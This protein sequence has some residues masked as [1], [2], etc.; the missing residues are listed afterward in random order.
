M[1]VIVCRVECGHLDAV[2]A[3]GR[4]ERLH[5]SWMTK[6]NRTGASVSPCLT[7]TVEYDAEMTW[8]RVVAWTKIATCI[9]TPTA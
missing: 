4:L 9:T 2:L 1:R 3:E 6:R 8:A 7:L 5:G